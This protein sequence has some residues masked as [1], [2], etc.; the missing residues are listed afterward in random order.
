M[1]PT[2]EVITFKLPRHQQRQT[3]G[4]CG[5]L[6]VRLDG[7]KGYDAETSSGRALWQQVSEVIARLKIATLNPGP[8]ITAAVESARYGKPAAVTP[9]LGQGHSGCW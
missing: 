2:G 8:A 5:V 1:E 6:G 9:R 7:S 3:S 4:S